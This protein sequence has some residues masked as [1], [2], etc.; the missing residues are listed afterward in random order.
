MPYFVRVGPHAGPQLGVT[1]RG[2]F[3]TRKGS[4]LT[5]KWGPID[6][7]QD[8]GVRFWWRHPPTTKMYRCHSETAARRK[9]SELKAKKLTNAADH[10]GYRR[11]P[12]AT[13]IRTYRPKGA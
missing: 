1:S 12:G 4:T 9:Y 3:I 8:R 6:V 5:V 10:H 2:W 11:L 7:Y 13:I